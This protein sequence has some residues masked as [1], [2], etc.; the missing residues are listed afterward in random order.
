MDKAVEIDTDLL[1]Q[2]LVATGE[3]QPAG[4]LAAKL[5]EMAPGASARD[6]C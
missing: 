2:V 1:R 6:D 3:F 4:N 5:V